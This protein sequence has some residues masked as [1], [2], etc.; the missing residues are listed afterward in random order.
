MELCAGMW[1][2]LPTVVNTGLK[3]LNT[4]KDAEQKLL[5]CYRAKCNIISGQNN[6]V[7]L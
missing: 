5:R 4:N 7:H 1:T 6:I 3:I 2:K